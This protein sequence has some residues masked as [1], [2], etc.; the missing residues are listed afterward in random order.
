MKAIPKTILLSACLCLSTAGVQ[1]SE[2]HTEGSN[3]VPVTVTQDASFSVTL[4]AQVTFTKEEL[5]SGS[6]SYNIKCVADLPSGG[7]VTVSSKE[8][9]V[10][11]SSGK[12]SIGLVNSVHDNKATFRDTEG[13]EETKT[14]SYAVDSSAKLYAGNY[15]VNDTFLI[16]VTTTAD[17]YA[18]YGGQSLSDWEYAVESDGN[19]AL[20]KYIG[21]GSRVYVPTVLDG[22]KV[23]RLSDLDTGDAEELVVSDLGLHGQNHISTG[24]K[25]AISITFNAWDDVQPGILQ[26][27]TKVQTVNLN[28]CAALGSA[29]FSGC[30]N[31]TTVNGTEDVTTFNNMAFA[32][33]SSLNDLKLSSAATYGWKVTPGCTALTNVNWVDSDSRDGY[34]KLSIFTEDSPYGASYVLGTYDGIKYTTDYMPY[35]VVS[36]ESKVDVLDGTKAFS[37][38]YAP[39]QDSYRYH[40]KSVS[41]PSSL[42]KIGTGE[43]QYMWGLNTELKLPDNLEELGAVTFT[44]AYSCP[45]S[46][47]TIPKSVK[48]IGKNI[49]GGVVVPDHQFYMLGRYAGK[50]KSYVVEDGNENYTASD[51][52]LYTKDLST[53][54]AVP[55]NKSFAAA[56]Y[57]MPEGTVTCGGL[58]L[59]GNT[60]VKTIQLSDT[61]VIDND[62][63]NTVQQCTLNTSSN[64]LQFCYQNNNV[65]EF[66]VKSSNTRYSSFNGCIYSKDGTELVSVPWKHDSILQIKPGCTTVD[67]NAFWYN[68]TGA[69]NTTKL[70]VLII[71]SSLQSI[72][73]ETLLHLNKSYIAADTDIVFPDG[74]Q[75]YTVDSNNKLVTGSCESN[76][77]T[78]KTF[79]EYAKYKAQGAYGTSLSDWNSTKVAYNTCVLISPTNSALDK[80]TYVPYYIF[81][82]DGVMYK[83]SAQARLLAIQQGAADNLKTLVIGT[84]YTKVPN[85]FA[86]DRSETSIVL[87]STC[88]VLGDECFAG[89]GERATCDLT[90]V[91]Q[92]G[93]AAL[94]SQAGT[95]TIPDTLTSIGSDAFIGCAIYMNTTHPLY[96]TAADE[97]YWEATVFNDEPVNQ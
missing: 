66:S 69:Y 47:V 9:T 89:T 84:G 57:K 27:N 90:Y 79:A 16:N 58:G 67:K 4:P 52:I 44:H 70:S 3:D 53:I 8:A 78:S 35:L 7:L 60:S 75:Y 6:K 50:F 85:K 2:V 30:I 29:A 55:T 93:E 74:S 31:L 45:N 48:V 80:V 87:P 56:M 71:P 20:T 83:C 88:T 13:S 14:A 91:V 12:N 54:V 41:F 38:C 49:G 77:A 95:Y 22:K 28:S 63:Y 68:T 26:N 11:L 21:S 72:D 82:D 42:V 46:T 86:T 64:L 81:D 73:E 37:V 65:S 32:N 96:T 51:G 61:F 34:S 43:F 23:N 25:D 40:L 39:A 1:A 76:L 97:G 18:D 17:E 94:A 19:I 92:I 5:A 15:T 24:N 33:C 59:S 10:S 62:W 36:W